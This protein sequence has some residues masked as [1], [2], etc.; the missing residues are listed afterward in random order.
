[1]NSTPA[2]LWVAS[3]ALCVFILGCISIYTGSPTWL[4]PYPLAV[5]VP[6]L[7]IAE[8]SSRVTTSANIAILLA[9]GALPISLAYL[10]WSPHLLKKSPIL[11][12]R[13]I[14]LFVIVAALTMWGA[15]GSWPYGLKY[16]GFAYTLYVTAIGVVA[17][18]VLGAIGIWTRMSP[19]FAKNFAFHTLL[20]AWLAWGAFPWLGELP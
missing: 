2:W 5:V 13:S 10:L 9:L 3:G 6:A 18:V 14:V 4:S 20:F 16:Q 12:R 1:M 7:W 19:S 17:L 15:I 8:L 11:P